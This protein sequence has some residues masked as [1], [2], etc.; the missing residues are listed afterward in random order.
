MMPRLT[1]RAGSA[2]P[3]NS[4][5]AVGGTA[6]GGGFVLAGGGL[7]AEGG[8]G[9]GVLPGGGLLAAGG[10]AGGVL[11]GGGIGLVGGETGLPDDAERGNTA[12]FG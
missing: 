9:G 8:L 12:K 2:P 1:G 10:L 7:P 5:R 4:R 11:T 3:R 6:P